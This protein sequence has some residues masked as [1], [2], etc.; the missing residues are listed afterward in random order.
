MILQ[1]NSDVQ[2]P[3]LPEVHLD[4][5][6]GVCRLEKLDGDPGRSRK[7]S[8]C[9][10]HS[11]EFACQLVPIGSLFII[12]PLNGQCPHFRTL[13]SKKARFSEVLVGVIER[14]SRFPVSI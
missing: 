5:A 8:P 11:R 2:N 10:L 7:G 12:I 1:S 14:A 4:S 3:D 9:I 6:Y 13:M